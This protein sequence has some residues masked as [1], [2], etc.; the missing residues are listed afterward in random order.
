[1][2][3]PVRHTGT[4]LLSPHWIAELRCLGGAPRLQ[5]LRLTPS[6]Q[7]LVFTDMSE[8]GTEVHHR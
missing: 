1:M 2:F 3:R 4:P 8:H 7:A 6:R 5:L